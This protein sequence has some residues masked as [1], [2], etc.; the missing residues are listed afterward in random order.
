MLGEDLIDEVLKAVNSCSI[1]QGWNDTAIVMIPKI[2]SPEKVTQ[3]RPISL[4]NVV[5]KVISK[6]LAARLKVFL[7]DIISPTQSPFVPGR[8]ITD[9]VLVAYE[10]FHA[11]KNRRDGQNGLC[12]VKLDM[13]KAYDR[14]EWPFLQGILIKFGFNEDWVKLVM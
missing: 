1:P 12:A 4:C 9:N 8:L 10:S 5:Y 7:P 14:V 2:N 6:M 13:H 3:F 11:M